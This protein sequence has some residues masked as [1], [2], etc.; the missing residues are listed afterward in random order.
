MLAAARPK[1]TKGVDETIDS[2]DTV[3][4]LI[5]T[6]RTTTAAPASPEPLDGGRRLWRR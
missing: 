3:E 6:C 2:V 1:D 4:W 5:R